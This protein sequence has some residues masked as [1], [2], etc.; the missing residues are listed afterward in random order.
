[1]DITYKLLLLSISM[2]TVFL[3]SSLR[4]GVN[5][6]VK[7]VKEAWNDHAKIKSLCICRPVTIFIAHTY[8]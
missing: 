5:N 3:P 7:I 4:P 6:D 1:M 8:V 2:A